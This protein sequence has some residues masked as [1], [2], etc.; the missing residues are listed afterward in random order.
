MEDVFCSHCGQKNIINRP[1]FS[2]LFAT[3]FKDLIN[4]DNNFWQAI[5]ILFLKPG[6]IVNQYLVGKRTSFVSP[7]KLYFF[8]SLFTFLLP[9]ILIDFKEVDNAVQMKSTSKNTG[10]FHFD[11]SEDSKAII[12]ADSV[13]NS[14]SQVKNDSI[15]KKPEEYDTSNNRLI[16]FSDFPLYSKA[17]EILRPWGFYPLFFLLHTVIDFYCTAFWLGRFCSS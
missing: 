9:S 1:S 2:Y 5:S 3:F 17:M 11:F 4:Y 14:I 16:S 15:E 10:V 7:I 13:Q 6:V 8:I 12:V